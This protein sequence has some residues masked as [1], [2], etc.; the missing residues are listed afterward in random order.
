MHDLLVD[1]WLNIMKVEQLRCYSTKSHD[2]GLRTD[3]EEILIQV[4]HYCY[5]LNPMRHETWP[6]ISLSFLLSHFIL[7]LCFYFSNRDSCCVTTMDKTRTSY[8]VTY[9]LIF[10]S[11]YISFLTF[12]TLHYLA[13]LTHKPR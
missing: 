13:Q 10:S 5:S 3:L 7:I 11:L 12:D 4:Q 1:E 8:M 6:N 2:F 9:T